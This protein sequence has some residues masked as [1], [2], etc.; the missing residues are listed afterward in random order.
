MKY[1]ALNSSFQEISH[2]ATVNRVHFPSVPT[3]KPRAVRSS[4]TTYPGDHHNE[5]DDHLQS[6]SDS[7]D[8]GKDSHS[9]G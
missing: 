3:I 9:K 8:I 2:T 4:V 5:T 7:R 6:E 1:R